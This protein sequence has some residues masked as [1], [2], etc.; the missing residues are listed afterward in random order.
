M[1]IIINFP[2]E[3]DLDTAIIPNAIYNETIAKQTEKI[4]NY[5]IK[6]PKLLLSFVG[7]NSKLK[8]AE[9]LTYNKKCGCFYNI[10]WLTYYGSKNNT[11]I[12]TLSF[13]QQVQEYRYMIRYWYPS[14]EISHMQY[15]SNI[16]LSMILDIK[17]F[18]YYRSNN[19]DNCKIFIRKYYTN[20]F[21]EQRVFINYLNKYFSGI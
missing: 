20:N 19:L 18:R 17:Q 1:T 16:A 6:N 9:Q 5:F 15:L 12:T 4:A 13:G 21:T 3:G 7:Y 11:P 14:P 2:T 8:Q 10:P